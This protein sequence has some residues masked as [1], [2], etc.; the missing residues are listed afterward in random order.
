MPLNPRRTADGV[1]WLHEGHVVSTLPARPGPTNSIF[2]LIAAA[3]AC[4]APAGKPVAMLGFAGG[5]TIAPLRALGCHSPVFAADLDVDA[6]PLF[7]EVA[8]NWA[9]E[10]SVDCAEATAWLLGQRRHFGVIIDDLSI[11]VPGDVVKPDVSLHVLPALFRKR[12]VH[13][14]IGL[15]NLIPSPGSPLAAQVREVSKHFIEARLVRFAEYSNGLLIVGDELLEPR[16]MGAMLKFHLEHMGSKMAGRF[17]VR[18][19]AA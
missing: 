18:N 19:V 3:T 9:G 14:G 15:F 2:D 6:V 8:G 12:L 11:Q 5:G 17:H 16:S 13:C 10:V 4:L 1:E 7:R